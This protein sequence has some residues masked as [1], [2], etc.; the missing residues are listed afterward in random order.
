MITELTW[1]CG[2][3]GVTF[4]AISSWPVRERIPF[5]ICNVTRDRRT[6]ELLGALSAA[7]QAKADAVLEAEYDDK[8]AQN[9][10]RRERRAIGRFRMQLIQS[11]ADPDYRMPAVPR[12]QA[13]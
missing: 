2:I 13:N 9:R 1:V 5:N 3:L 7:H 12:R 10:S 8:V 6:A 11:G 4:I